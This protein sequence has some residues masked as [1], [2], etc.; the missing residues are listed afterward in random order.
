MCWHD[1]NSGRRHGDD[2]ALIR[3]LIGSHLFIDWRAF[4]PPGIA[5]LGTMIRRTA[6][7]SIVAAAAA[8]AVGTAVAIGPS[9]S[10]P[11]TVLAVAE[12]GVMEQV[13]PPPAAATAVYRV[14]L[15]INWT[16]ATHPGTLPG[17]AH[18]SAPVVAVHSTPGAM[19]AVGAQASPGIEAMAERGV[20]STLVN[21]LRASGLATEVRTG[22]GVPFPAVGT[23]TFDVSV[24]Q[25][26]NRISLV[27]MLAPSPDWFVGFAD[28]ST[29]VDSQW[30]E[31]ATFALGNYDSGT[32]SGP[33]FTSGNADSQPRQTISGPRDAA[34]AAAAAQAPFGSVTI[35][36][37][38]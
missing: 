7:A 17:N 35:T 8:L 22:A 2:R 28:R 29:F 26:A 1:D 33:S 13:N 30:I 9:I 24:S 38:G 3:D 6:L 11:A 14:T 15:N 16:S 10:A 5:T 19:F 37:V 12:R 21:E 4:V 20:T 36:K 32:D 25:S 23:R 31:S 34:F 18:V 27:T